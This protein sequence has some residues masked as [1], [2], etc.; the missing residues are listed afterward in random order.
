[1]KL[2]IGAHGRLAEEIVNS[3]NM[4]FGK[5]ED[6][7]TISFVPGE[8][9]DDLKRKYEEITSDNSEEILFLVDLFGGSPY[10][11][12]FQIAM[13]EE[14]MDVITGLSLPM[15]IDVL[16]IREMQENV[17][18]SEVYEKLNRD[19]YMKSCKELLKE[20]VEEEDL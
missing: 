11:A 15:L 3:A 16:G 4:V 10:N 9:G 5:I 18:A 7:Y 17:K 13:M 6:I 1:M 8:N 20:V 19:S 2:I 14:R 12:A